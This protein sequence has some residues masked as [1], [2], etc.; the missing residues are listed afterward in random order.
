MAR[1]T[2]E[3][4][5]EEWDLTPK[6]WYSVYNWERVNGEAYLEQISSWLIAEWDQMKLSASGSRTRNFRVPDHLGQ[7]DI[8]TGIGQVTEKRLVRAA[9]NLGTLE[10]FGQILDYEVPL[11]E[12]GSSHGDID[13]LC[14]HDP[15]LFL[16]EAKNPTNSDSVLKPL[17]QAFV[18]SSLVARARNV[19]LADYS[20]PSAA[21]LVPAVLVH[22]KSKAARQLSDTARFQNMNKLLKLIG[23]TL[24]SINIAPIKFF[25][26]RNPLSELTECLEVSTADKIVF[27][28]GVSLDIVEL[29]VNGMADS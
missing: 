15:N 18:Y 16:V 12:A 25:V 28:S 3:K 22:E 4:L 10:P 5:R 14:W 1:I 27:R 8:Q 19:F 2:D 7:A 6:D 9:Y 11:S 20:I 24:V 29:N 23:E 26:I 21:C 13:L 17:L